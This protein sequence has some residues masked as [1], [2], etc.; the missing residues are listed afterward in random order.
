MFKKRRQAMGNAQLSLGLVIINTQQEILLIRKK[1]E[2]RW[3]LC[4]CEMKIGE[5]F[6]NAIKKSMREFFSV[7]GA[8][9]GGV[10]Y[11]GT[12][13]LQEEYLIGGEN[14]VSILVQV[15]IQRPK[16]IITPKWWEAK[17][18]SIKGLS[19]QNNVASWLGE[20]LDRLSRRIGKTD[21]NLLTVDDFDPES[22]EITKTLLKDME[23]LNDDREPE[24]PGD[25]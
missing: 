7:I 24:W 21:G 23:A 4:W 14:S 3:H 11:L 25:R 1:D 12:S 10:V 5:S 16:K 19:K 15:I 9:I 2:K 13:V 6:K 18:F 22:F 17:W 8:E 20:E